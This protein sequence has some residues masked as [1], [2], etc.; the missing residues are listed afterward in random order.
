MVSL[1]RSRTNHSR[2][3]RRL[4]DPEEHFPVSLV[5]CEAAAHSAVQERLPELVGREAAGSVSGHRDLCRG[6][7][8]LQQS[9]T[10]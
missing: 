4:G 10:V 1:L 3:L 2:R 5:A 8:L 7:Q 6:R 9:A